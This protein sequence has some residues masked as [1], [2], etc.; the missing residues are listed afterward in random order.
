MTMFCRLFDMGEVGVLFD[1]SSFAGR[2][3][4]ISTVQDLIIPRSRIAL[5]VRMTPTD[6]TH[7]RRV[8]TG[9]HVSARQA[10]NR[11]MPEPPDQRLIS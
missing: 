4:F 11:N 5:I 7:A 9:L 8:R 3:H 2:G 10:P 6:A 1:L